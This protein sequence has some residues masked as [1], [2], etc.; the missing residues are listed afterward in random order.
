MSAVETFIAFLN[1]TLIP[2]L[3]ES[4]RYIHAADFA[5]AIKFMQG[6]KKVG[7]YNRKTFLENLETEIKLAEDTGYQFTVEDFRTCYAF[8]YWTR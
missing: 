1:E 3:K 7:E 5:I 6:A 2:D 8:I 4:K